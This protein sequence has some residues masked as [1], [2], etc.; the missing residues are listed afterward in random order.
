MY[1]SNNNMNKPDNVPD[2]SLQLTKQFISPSA[3]SSSKPQV[4]NLP[5]SAIVVHQAPDDER[6]ENYIDRQFTVNDAKLLKNRLSEATTLRNSSSIPIN[7]KDVEK[8]IAPQQQLG[9]TVVVPLSRLQDDEQSERNVWWVTKNDQDGFYSICG[10]LFLFGFI[11]P[12]FWWIGSF[13]PKHVREKG[14]KMA[15]RWQKLNRVM[16]IG[17]SSIIVI[18]ILVFVV[19]YATGVY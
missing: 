2:V 6:F 12:P 4:S 13:W 3:E 5:P 9:E 8:S 14:G 1:N 7:D 19:L 18:L 11:F 10:L 16:S 15:E 17:F